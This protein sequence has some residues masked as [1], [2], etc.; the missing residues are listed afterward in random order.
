MLNVGDKAPDFTLPS[1]S[2]TEISLKDFRGKPL[3]LYFFPK[4]DTPG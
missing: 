3:A 1:D 4:A 2:G